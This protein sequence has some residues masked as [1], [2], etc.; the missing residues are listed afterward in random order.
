MAKDFALSLVTQSNHSFMHNDT[1]MKSIISSFLLVFLCNT[2]IAQSHPTHFKSEFDFGNGTVISTFLDLA[3][4]QDQ[5]TITS[6]KNADKRIV[7]GKARL[8][9]LMGK[10]PKKGIIITIS[11]SQKSDSLFGET[12]IPMFGKLK[13]K[14]AVKNEVLSGKLLNDKDDPIGTLHGVAST[15]DKI[16]YRSLYAELLKT[17]RE[18]VYS[19]SVLQTEQWKKFEQKF[20]Q[21]CRT[22][23]DDIELFFGFNMLAQKLPFT[24]LSLM[25]AEDS[26]DDQP[27]QSSGKSVVFVEKNAT[28]AYLKIKNF[29]TSDSELE[30]VLPK[31]VANTAY[32]NLVID[33]RDNGGGGVGPAL[34][35][36][37]YIVNQDLEV[38]YFP[39]RRLNYSGYQPE[40]FAKLHEAESKSTSEF[41]KELNTTPGVKLVFKKPTNPVFSGKIY[42]LTNGNTASTCEPIVYALKKN[43]KATIVGEN[44]RGAMLAAFPFFVSGKYMLMVPIADYYAHD[45]ARLDKVGVAPD[46]AVKSADAEKRVM[47]M[48]GDGR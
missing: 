27:S 32:E 45:G 7:G 24:H 31:I 30:E 40:V 9:R 4:G 41:G 17:A 28:T 14:G 20:E 46:V 38:G 6:P 34:A 47:E 23:H 43:K 44:T 13:F 42:V 12:K 15:Q 39:T 36:A 18:N 10:L 22:A 21:L 1:K 8:G 26:A 5:F 37:K 25:I 11:G 19:A 2:A 3:T 16:D 48:I 29:S 33:L 35:L